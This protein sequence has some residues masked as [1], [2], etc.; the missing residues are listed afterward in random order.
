MEETEGQHSPY[1]RKSTRPIP[2]HLSSLGWTVRTLQDH[3]VIFPHLHRILSWQLIIWA[4]YHLPQHQWVHLRIFY[5]YTMMQFV[6]I[7][8]FISYV[9]PVHVLDCKINSYRTGP[10]GIKRFYRWI[11]LQSISSSS[12]IFTIQFIPN[13]GRISS[14]F[15]SLNT[16]HISLKYPLSKEMDERW[17]TILHLENELKV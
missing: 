2:Y 8:R 7:Q 9:V 15:Y 4:P 16:V 1:R 10:K 13:S 14:T 11:S 3:Q 17:K 5:V 6:Y 12:N